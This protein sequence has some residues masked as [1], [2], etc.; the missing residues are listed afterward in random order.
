MIVPDW[1]GTIPVVNGDADSGDAVAPVLP[2]SLTL[3][4]TGFGAIANPKPTAYDTFND[5]VGIG[6]GDE[7]PINEANPYWGLTKTSQYATTPILDNEI[8]LG[9]REYSI[10]TTSPRSALASPIQRV[11]GPESLQKSIYVSFWLRFNQNQGRVQDGGDQPSLTS[12]K[13]IR[14]WDHSSGDGMRLSYTGADQGYYC[15]GVHNYHSDAAWTNGKNEWHRLDLHITQGDY[16]AGTPTVHKVWNDGKLLG[17]YEDVIETGTHDGP[18][19]ATQLIDSTKDWYDYGDNISDNI[20]MN[21]S[22]H[23]LWVRNTTDGSHGIVA[24]PTLVDSKSMAEV[25]LT[26]GTT[27]TWS[28]GDT[29]EVVRTLGS[30]PDG[31]GSANKMYVKILGLDISGSEL[32]NPDFSY[33]MADFYQYPTMATVELSNSQFYDDSVEQERVLQ[34]TTTR[35]DNEIVIPELFFGNLDKSLPIYPMVRRSDGSV[36]DGFE[37]LTL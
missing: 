11:D 31:V 4:G 26:G 21:I 15:N 20:F 10:K 30:Y 8:T 24:G 37:A 5:Y 2:T 25:P 16:I 27:N 28:T 14:I 34:T 13:L 36:I 17:T 32:M 35:T 1:S 22:G 9:D 6:H 7:I 12:N 33:R 29:Y 18:T 3:T 19:H 23:G